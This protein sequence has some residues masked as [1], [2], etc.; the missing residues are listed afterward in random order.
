[1]NLAKIL[2]HPIGYLKKAIEEQLEFDIKMLQIQVIR[3]WSPAGTKKVS[4]RITELSKELPETRLEMATR[5]Y[6][7]LTRSNHEPLLYVSKIASH[8]NSVAALSHKM[9]EKIKTKKAG[10]GNSQPGPK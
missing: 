10:P 1:M 8:H 6:N 5:I 3:G 9:G 4:K 7:D 2:T